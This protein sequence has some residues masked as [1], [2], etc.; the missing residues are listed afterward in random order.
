MAVGD[1]N[2]DGNADVVVGNQWEYAAD[3]KSGAGRGKGATATLGTAKSYSSGVPASNFWL[4]LATSIKTESSTSW[5]QF[6]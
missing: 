5:L 3:C 1:F 4:R 2:G 6:M